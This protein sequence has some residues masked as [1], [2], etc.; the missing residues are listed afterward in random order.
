[1][2]SY[3]KIDRW[4][5]L[6]GTAYNNVIQVNQTILTNG[7]YSASFSG[8]AQDLDQSYNQYSYGNAIYTANAYDQ[9]SGG[10]SPNG[11]WVVPD[12]SVKIRPRLLTS[13]IL[14]M[15]ELIY[16]SSYWEVQG[17]I[18][19]NGV[20]IGLGKPRGSRFACTFA[21]N[22]YEY[23]GGSTY[24]QYSTYK[25]SV[26]LLDDPFA[27]LQDD[28]ASG[29]NTGEATAGPISSIQTLE[30]WVELNSYS[31]Q[32]ITVNKPQYTNNDTSYWAEPISTLTV[33]EVTA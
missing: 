6:D 22:N 27:S 18:M 9:Y 14:V 12:F 30:Y 11:W 2:T 1:M 20:G 4:N 16:G 25:A 29:T 7:D 10:M 21:D 33:M 19:R 3:A 13:K 32:T 28:S 24:S 5:R 8:A 17:R 15:L 31:G 26:T 23:S